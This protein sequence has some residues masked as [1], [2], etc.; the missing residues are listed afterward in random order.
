MRI[1]FSTLV[2][3]GIF[4]M[5]GA[6]C[7]KTTLDYAG[8]TPSGK[9]SQFKTRYRL[10]GCL[11]DQKNL[12]LLPNARIDYYQT[13]TAFFEI[14]GNDEGVKVTNQ[15][16]DHLG[17]FFFVHE[18]NLNKNG[19]LYFIPSDPATKHL[20]LRYRGGTYEVRKVDGVLRPFGGAPQVCVLTQVK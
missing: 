10:L 19:F 15:W 14:S 9:P 16:K 17:Q 7:F 6:G 11:D 5:F 13:D 20:H 2:I 4:L 18:K 12:V 3:T 1:H 8:G